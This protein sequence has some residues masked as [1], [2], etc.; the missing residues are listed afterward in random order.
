MYISCCLLTISFALVANGNTVFSG[1]WALKFHVHSAV[2]LLGLN[3]AKLTLLLCQWLIMES[4]GLAKNNRD[5]F[6]YL[7][8]EII[9]NNYFSLH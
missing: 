1:I 6:I 4:M 7:F 2:C 5:R 9:G 3:Q 8:P